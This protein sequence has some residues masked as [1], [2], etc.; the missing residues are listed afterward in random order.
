MKHGLLL[1]ALCL[2]LPLLA[3]ADEAL[4]QG[5]INDLLHTDAY[6]QRVS[7]AAQKS[8]VMQANP[9][10][11]GRYGL[12][13]TP[14]ILEELKTDADR[15]INAG[16]WKQ[17]IRFEGCGNNHMLNVV[18]TVNPDHTMQL[19]PI[20]PGATELDYSLQKEAVKRAIAAV[21]E[22]TQT[23]DKGYVADTVFVKIAG[24]AQQGTN[25]APWDEM[26]TLIYCDKKAE[27]LMHFIP[28][29]KGIT[30]HA[31]GAETKVTSLQ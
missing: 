15:L 29:A 17:P 16:K 6:Q 7:Q 8:G 10:P 31:F 22:R 2:S 28:D 13:E 9:C 12:M 23:C 24:T 20:L 3:H 26:W 11:S 1:L 4:D 25:K 18:T 27:V 14:V 19:Q 30:T 5:M 21:G